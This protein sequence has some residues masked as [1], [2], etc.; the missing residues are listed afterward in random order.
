MPRVG[1]HGPSSAQ[2]V[3]AG[4]DLR[5][6][7]P[8]RDWPAWAAE[9]V[10]VRPPDAGWAQ[11]GDQECRLLEARLASWLVARVEHVGSTAVPGLAAKPILDL[12]AAVGDLHCAPGIAAVLASVGWHYVEP[13]IDGRSWRRFFVKVTDGRRAAHLHVMTR[14][15]TRW[16]EQLAFRDALRADPTLVESYAALKGTLAAQHADDREAYTAA[17]ADFVQTVLDRGGTAMHGLQRAP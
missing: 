2:R 8:V 15:S 5:D 13:E 14:N 11:S 3:C 10:D 7:L 6:D 1:E 17:K 12:Q 9:R 4:I 16:D